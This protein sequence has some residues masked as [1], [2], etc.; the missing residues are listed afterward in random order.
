MERSESIKQLAT[1][2]VAFQSE[3]KK[4]IKDATNPFFKSSYAT[5]DNIWKVISE[6]LARNGLAVTQIPDGDALLCMLV[7]TSGEFI[8]GRYMIN[9]AGKP[10]EVGSAITYAR[11][12]S[13]SAILGLV[14]EDDDDA[15]IANNAKTI[16]K[17]VKCDRTDTKLFIVQG[18]EYHVCPLHAPT[19]L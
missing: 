18:K 2:L 13:L 1:A 14:T 12:Y 5:L 15:N 19:N 7:H 8:S 16:V 9:T 6:P 11:R 10:Q 4:I 3:T 17:C